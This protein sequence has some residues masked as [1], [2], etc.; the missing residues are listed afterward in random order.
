M[1]VTELA[2][3]HLKPDAMA[4]WA[5]LLQALSTAKS[6]QETHSGSPVTYLQQ[7]EDLSILY[8]VGAWESPSAHKSSISSQENRALLEQFKD[9][10]D[11]QDIVM[12]HLTLDMEAAP[13]PLD[14]PVVSINRHFVKKGQTDAFHAKLEE[15][16][17]LLTAFTAPRAVGGGWRIEK[18]TDAEGEEME[19]WVLFSGFDSVE[20]YDRFVQT[21]EFA[22]YRAITESIDGFEVK[23]ARKL[24]VVET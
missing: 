19:E 8:V 22:S 21:E 23:H 12:Y 16:K 20:H 18:E 13:L 1:P 5:V 24:E 3:L 10:I 11:I 2:T 7:V 6:V 9:M 15:V 4:R 17:G 14:A